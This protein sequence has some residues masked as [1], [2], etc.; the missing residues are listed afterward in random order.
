MSP[1]ILYNP[2]LTS[3]NLI[4]SKTSHRYAQQTCLI[5]VYYKKTFFNGS[6]FQPILA[7]VLLTCFKSTQFHESAHLYVHSD[8]VTWCGAKRIQIRAVESE[9]KSNPNFSDFFQ[10]SDFI[11]FF[12]QFYPIFVR[13]LSDFFQFLDFSRFLDLPIPQL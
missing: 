6:R 13:C 9:F 3:N 12:I 4:M 7:E 2:G 1:L 10:F 5:G 8:N 11:R